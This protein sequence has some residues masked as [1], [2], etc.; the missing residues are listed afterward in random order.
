[1]PGSVKDR[2]LNE[3][4]DD[5]L[6]WSARR[7][8]VSVCATSEIKDGGQALETHAPACSNRGSAS[9]CLTRG[10]AADSTSSQI[11]CRTRRHALTASGREMT[12]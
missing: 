5:C 2:I 10:I 12:D 4:L 6:E 11:S 7:M 9:R 1:M 8:V 3:R